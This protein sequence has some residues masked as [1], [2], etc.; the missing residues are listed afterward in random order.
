MRNWKPWAKWTAGAAGAALLLLALLLFTPPGLALVGRMVRPLTGGAVR[1]DHLSGT[2]PNRLRAASVEIADAQGVWLRLTDIALDWSAFSALRNHI[3]VRDVTAARIAVLRRPIP[4]QSEGGE[5]P[6]ITVAHFRFA[7]I[8]I[9]APVIGRQAALTAQGA[10]AYTSRHQLSADATASRLDNGDRYRI[11]GGI[12][13]DVAQ[14]SIA[15]QEG[16]DG[17]LG[18]LAGLPGLGPVNLQARADGSSAANTLAFTLTAGPL[19]AHGQGTLQLA[20]ERAD[21]AFSATA[22][23]MTLRDGLSW[24]SLSATGRFHGGFTQPQIE[25]YLIIGDGTFDTLKAEQIALNIIGNAGRANLEAVVTGLIMPGAAAD[26]F[27]HQPVTV[28]AGA[29]LKA[30][31]RPVTFTVSHPL[32][33]LQG[34]ATTRGAVTATAQLAIP[35]LAPFAATQGIDMRGT[36]G[37]DIAVNQAGLRTQMRLQGRMDTQGDAIPVRL[38]GRDARLDF[39]V[40]LENS[41]VVESTVSLRGAAITA[42]ASGTVRKGV[43]GYGVTFNLSDLSRLSDLLQ[44][45]LAMRGD[46]NGPLATAA[47]RARGTAQIA[48]KG[49]AQ[50]QITIEMEAS[51]LPAPRA[52]RLNVQGRLNGA[53]LAVQANLNGKAARQLALT[54]RW[55]SLEASGDVALPENA[56]VT[57]RIR[58]AV[59]QLAD[60]AIFTGAQIMGTTNAVL[61]LTAN[62]GKTDAQLT[63]NLSGAQTGSMRLGNADLRGRV[64][65]LFGSRAFDMTVTAQDMNAGGFTGDANLQLDGPQDRLAIRLLSDMKDGNGTAAHLDAA[66]LV[67]MTAGNVTLQSLS[68]SWRGVELALKAPAIVDYADGLSIDGLAARLGG[69][70]IT[71]SG[72]LMPNLQLR[73]SAQGIALASLK[74]FLPSLGEG[75][76]AATADLTG[77]LAAP[78]GSVTL[79][80]SGLRAAFSSRAVPPATLEARAQL[81]GG[82]A[83]VTASLQAGNATN[84]TATGETGLAMDAPIDLHAKGNA[85]LALLDP[86][87]AADGRRLRGTLAFETGIAGTLAA[88]RVSGSGQL[89]DGE[90]Q[91]YLRGLQVQDITAAIQAQGADIRITQFQGRAGKGTLAGSGSINLSEAGLP[92]ALTLEAKNA[93]PIVS[94]LFTATLSGNVKMAGTLTRQLAL[95]G[96]IQVLGGEINLPDNFPPEV[97]VLNVRQ[98]GRPAPPPPSTSRVN[99]DIAVRTT[100][101]IFVRGHGIDAEMGGAIRIGGT[102]TAP[103]ISGGFQMN[104]GSYDA[105]GQ[106]LDF[107]TGRIGFDGTG[108]RNRFDPTLDFVAQTVSGGITARLNVTGYASAPRIVLSSTPPLP[109]D[110]IVS[111]LLFRQ[112]IKQLTPLQLASIAQALAAMGGVG[113]SLNPLGAVRRN[114]GLDRLSVGSSG[115]AGEQSR[116]TVEAGRYVSRGVYV[117]VKQTLSGGTQ[118]QVQV[119]ITQRLKAQATLSTGTNATTVRRPGE[120]TGSSIGLAY[121]LEY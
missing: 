38:L 65:Y 115:A 29:D 53:P 102:S 2:F 61:A 28:K 114:L 42:D 100:G 47:L 93:R 75:T 66:A 40:V 13:Q 94:D 30:S 99:L 35:A 118:T 5:T 83:T 7:R 34:Q 24:Q 21:V 68:G 84:L 120:D 49:F 95:S 14:G 45:S 62:R 82:R 76:I 9:Q 15:I 86:L 36:A 41:D 54:A 107:T 104:R 80:G 58:F 16:A 101:P 59:G 106:R 113:G 46:A 11:H 33:N 119:D 4:S 74:S 23:Q 60:V 22:P 90:F 39:N 1:I 27:A 78:Q 79:R 81:V 57:G 55:K 12:A 87:L 111:R 92:V 20:A 85:D 96:E 121:E 25:A 26:L 97:A 77:T 64:A 98:R 89:S 6:R 32:M 109:Q 8:V 51:G 56:P 73:A 70:D 48:T 72:Q 69:G 44:G 31:S 88:P 17:I 3:N 37:L 117:G 105:A 67:N 112:D 63:A 19:N 108:L 10:L 110:E 18:D 52:G 103:T 71:A 116:T 43:L 91:D 50:Q